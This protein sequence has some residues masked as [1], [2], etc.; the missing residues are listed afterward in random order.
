MTFY[1][2]C[3]GGELILTT[4]GSSPMASQWPATVQNHILHASLSWGA[5]VLLASD[6]KG[7]NASIRGN[8]I[9]LALACRS[10][11]EIETFFQKLS[12]GGQVIHPLHAF[13][14]GT[15]GA[16]TDKYGMHWVLK[17]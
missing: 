6:M 15:I 17:Y 5:P 7:P 1:Q 2:H 16:L 11:Q 10:Q 3:L 13:F 14:D 9:S 4:V 8:M 12:S